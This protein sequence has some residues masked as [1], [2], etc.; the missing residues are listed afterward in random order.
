MTTIS[1][2]EILNRLADQKT[3]QEEK[4]MYIK[5]LGNAGSHEAREQLQKTLRDQTQALCI[6]VECVWALRRIIHVA[7]EKVSYLGP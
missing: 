6:R 1:K 2:Q 3:T 4:Q 5:A 7:R